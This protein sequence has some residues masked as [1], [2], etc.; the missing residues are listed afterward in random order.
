MKRAHTR[1]PI[2]MR[3]KNNTKKK[4]IIK[5][6]NSVNDV[7]QTSNSINIIIIEKQLSR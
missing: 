6:V 2:L 3:E 5:E 4:T 7:G 1:N